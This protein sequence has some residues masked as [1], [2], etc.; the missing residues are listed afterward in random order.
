MPLG[1]NPARSHA[2]GV[3]AILSS[4][5]TRIFLHRGDTGARKKT[6]PDVN[7]ERRPSAHL[8]TRQFGAALAS[9]D[10]RWALVSTGLTALVAGAVAWMAMGTQP[11][12]NPAIGAPSYTPLSYE[13]FLRLVHAG[14]PAAPARP[15]QQNQDEGNANAAPGEETR[16]FTLDRGDTLAG[17]MEDVGVSAADANA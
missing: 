11:M 10:G 5:L 13:L 9:T 14:A 16:S 1:L 7:P 3:R 15:V 2:G 6:G 4:G 17:A 12:Q 8:R